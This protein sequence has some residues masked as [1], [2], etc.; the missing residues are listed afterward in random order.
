MHSSTVVRAAL[1][2]VAVSLAGSSADAEVLLT[3]DATNQAAVTITATS[4]R[5]ALSSTG[6][7]FRLVLRDSQPQLRDAFVN[8]T[9][10]LR[11]AQGSYDY[12]QVQQ[13]DDAAAPGVQLVRIP[14]IRQ[15]QTFVAGEVAFLGTETADL[16]TFSLNPIG[17]TY[18]IEILNNF[19]QPTGQIVGQYTL[20]VPEPAGL[21]LVMIGVAPM[22]RRRRRAR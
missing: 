19:G 21:S 1:V 2:A 8:T 15:T 7:N 17:G 18:D 3:I 12:G 4:G 16:S 11:T 9:G 10:D 6:E 22:L 14:S 13:F 20:I 5:S